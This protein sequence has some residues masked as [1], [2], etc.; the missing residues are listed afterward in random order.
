[1]HTVCLLTNLHGSLSVQA[2]GLWAN[3]G[4]FGLTSVISPSRDEVIQITVITTDKGFSLTLT[5]VD[6]DKGATTVKGL[7]KPLFQV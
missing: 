6:T 5:V 3:F 1:M 2:E 7:T 4:Q